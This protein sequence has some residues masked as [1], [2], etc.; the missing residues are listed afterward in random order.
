MPATLTEAEQELI[1]AEAAYFSQCVPNPVA[2]KTYK[3]LGAAAASGRLED[4]LLPALG[5]LLELGFTSGRIRAVYGAHAEMTASGLFRRTP[6]GEALH[7]QFQDANNA[8]AA[9]KGQEVESITLT[10]RGPGLYTLTIQTRDFRLV[11]ALSHAGIDV[12]SV[13][14]AL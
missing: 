3:R 8:L 11:A 2:R 12:R 9:L 4:D 1:A 10:A 7:R 6:Q 14:V 5:G 13:E